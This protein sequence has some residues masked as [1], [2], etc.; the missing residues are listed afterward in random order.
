[1]KQQTLGALRRI[2]L[3]LGVFFAPMIML[4]AFSGALQTFD[5][6]K[7]KDGAK[8]PAWLSVLAAAHKD[9]SLPRPKPPKPQCKPANVPDALAAN[10]PRKAGSPL[11]L[12]I[13]VTLLSIGLIIASG[14]GILVALTSKATAK[15]S[16]AALAA[17]SI[18]PAALLLAQ[19]L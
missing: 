14:I 12:K 19:N 2:H 16:A 17:G 3:Y 8:P 13:F 7:T 15:M 11:P 1:M 9:Q 6:H 18:L 5:L 10:P 4:F